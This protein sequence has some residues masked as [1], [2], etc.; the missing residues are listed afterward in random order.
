MSQKTPS[1]ERVRKGQTGFAVGA[2][3]LREYLKT[4]PTNAGVYRMLADDGTVLYVGKAKNLKN[5]VTSYTQ[6][7]RLP[8]R[9]QR[10]V[11]QT[12]NMEI[13]I[14]HTETEALLLEANLIQRF[15]PPFN[16]LLR[17]DK[18]F[19]Y[20]LITK[21]H[22][23]PQ[24]SKHRGIKSRKGFY[25]GPF[26]SGG[27]VTETL[28]LMQRVFM[29][30][31]CSDS[32]FA[33]RSRPCL[34]YHIKRCT[35][36]CCAKVSKQDYACQVAEA[37]AFLRGQ[38]QDV[39]LRMAD[40]MQE[41]SESLNFERAASLRD[42]IR[43]LTSMQARQDINLAGLGDADVIALHQQ[44]GR[45]AIQVFFYRAD[46]NYG[47]R[48]YFPTHDKQ[49]TSGEVLGAFLA[50]FYADKEPPPLILLSEVPDQADLLA[51][52]LSE[53][54]EHKITLTVPKQDK[55]KR[56]VDHALTNAA[57]ALGRRLA[58]S[59][60][61]K[62]L[63]Q[64]VAVLFGMSKPPVRI[65]VYDNS[66]TSGTYA[67]GAM[68]A[69]GPEGF[70]KKTYRKFNIKNAQG[71]DDF[72]MMTEVLERRFSR[73]IKEDPYKKSGLWP[74]LLLIDGGAGQ[75][76]KVQSVL[77]ELGVTDVT[78]VG[79]AKGPDRNAGRERFF[80]PGHAP[81]SLPLQ[82]S[83]LYY[84]Q[85]LRD[86]AH[87]F[88]IGTHR[89]RRTKAI[90]VSGL[91]EVPGIGAVRKKALLQHFGSAKSVA[92]AGIEDLARVSGIS[93]KSAKIIYDYFHTGV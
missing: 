35:G 85:R 65:E 55:K 24:L 37:C 3:I 66:H 51:R 47:T 7:A 16:V 57:A 39:Q 83:T 9:L 71:N 49:V 13:V 31:T 22:E 17:D 4:M 54:A 43:V 67:V 18:S 78:L 34:Q 63:L 21:D 25:F 28:T 50:Q 42:R 90:G 86:E 41:A 58:D 2:S 60:E 80:I 5:R 59:V 44:A 73:L 46:R 20:I 45:S 36:P 53:R 32:Y 48:S 88:A 40:E 75:V 69:A 38:S 12:R 61:Q 70:L 92:G 68:I 8:N 10:M 14:T 6:Q 29:L 76:S 64:Q 77:Q 93:L 91:E 15:M 30:R 26:A 56:L 52:A 79:I 84:L 27:A 19:P 72:A 62:K 89:A 81:L 74:D 33:Q 11:A 1:A 87:R 82:D 23:F